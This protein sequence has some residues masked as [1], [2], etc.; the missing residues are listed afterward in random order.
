MGSVAPISMLRILAFGLLL[1]VT[2]A[3][4]VAAE[5][6]LAL[7]ITNAGYPNEVGRLDNPHKDG[8]TIAAALSAVGFE[9]GNV[10]VI[11]DAD[12]ASNKRWLTSSS[13]SRRRVRRPWPSSTTPA[14]ARPTGP[15]AA[16]TI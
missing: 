15:N 5:T 6:R 16:R 1:V 4:A 9:P 7:I 10:A 2:Q 3:T 8:T 14:T 13:A 11:K 12:Q